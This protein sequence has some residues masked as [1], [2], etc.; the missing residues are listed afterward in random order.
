MSKSVPEPALP[1]ATLL[2]QIFQDLKRAGLVESKRGPRGG[3]FLKR[4]P[5][6]MTLGDVVRAL[7]GSIEQMFVVNADDERGDRPASLP[8]T[9]A[10]WQELAQHVRGWFDG[11]SIAELV[12]RG[13]ELG[14][15]RAGSGQPMYFI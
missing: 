8:V 9:A 5:E 12:R 14:L 10:L 3:Y 2:E 11:V 15:S 4:T 7:Q 13:D 6:E 1:A